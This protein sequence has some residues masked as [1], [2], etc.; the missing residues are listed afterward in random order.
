MV[1]LRRQIRRWTREL[2]NHFVAGILI[3][4][5]IF[6]TVW[7]IYSIVTWIDEPT[8][9]LLN[10]IISLVMGPDTAPEGGWLPHYGVGFVVAIVVILFVGV[11]ARNFIGRK[12]VNLFERF[13]E[14]V[15]VFSRVYIAIRH[16]I[17]TFAGRQKGVFEAVALI[18]F[19]R[20][21]L[22]SIGLLTSSEHMHYFEKVGKNMVWV[23]V[24]T[25]PN[26]TSG[27]LV[28][29]ELENLHILDMTVEEAMKSIVSGGAVSPARDPL[30][31]PPLT[32]EDITKRNAR[33]QEEAEEDLPIPIFNRRKRKKDQKEGAL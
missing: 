11:F 5:P 1:S 13:L 17:H 31:D 2:R 30:P 15:P 24:P 10:R 33:R 4:L 9:D 19:P 22:W 27:Y 12:F 21:G 14:R 6:L 32:L 7:I 28:L 16:V 25:T 26:P 18:E 23:F 8:R 3:L 29:A 20:P